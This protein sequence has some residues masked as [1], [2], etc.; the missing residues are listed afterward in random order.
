[1][2]SREE[3]VGSGSDGNAGDVSSTDEVGREERSLVASGSTAVLA[4][5]GEGSDEST[6]VGDTS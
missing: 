6:V 1:M 4:G 5:E 2:G 3:E